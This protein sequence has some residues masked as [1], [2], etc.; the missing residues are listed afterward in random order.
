MPCKMAHKIDLLRSHEATTA[1]T[2]PSPIPD[3]VTIFV[4]SVKSCPK[5]IVVI[6]SRNASSA[7]FFIIVSILFV[8]KF[9]I[10]ITAHHSGV[11]KSITIFVPFL[12]R[13]D[14]SNNANRADYYTT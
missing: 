3:V 13:I 8:R 14:D 6:V 2:D 7:N 10:S 5:T 1:I 4:F 12:C 9:T 11:N